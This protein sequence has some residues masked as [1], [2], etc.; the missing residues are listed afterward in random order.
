MFQLAIESELIG[1]YAFGFGGLHRLQGASEICT[2]HAYTRHAKRMLFFRVRPLITFS[3]D[4]SCHYTHCCCHPSQLM[5]SEVACSDAIR[6]AR[7][8]RVSSKGLSSLA[9]VHLKRSEAGAHTVFKRFGQSLHV[10]IS[11]TDLPSKKNFPYVSFTSWLKYL[12]E[13]D[14][15]QHLVGE[16]D[17]FAMKKILATF[18]S[19]FEAIHPDHV[20]CGRTDDNFSKDMCIP[21]CYHGDEGRGLK[22]KQLMVLSIH[23]VLGKGSHGSN[24]MNNDIDDPLG[25][26]RLNMVGNTFLTHFLQCVVPISLYTDS[27]ESFFH[28]I[29]LQ[30]RE[31]ADLFHTGLQIGQHRYWICCVA[32]KGDAPYLTKSG[33]F[34]RSFTRRPTRA[35]SKN[36]AT[37]VCHLC[38]AGREN[39]Q[40]SH[41]PYEEIGTT[42]PLWLRTV[43]VERP[44]S[45]E[46]PMLQIPHQIG[47]TTE[48]LWQ[49]DLF[50][51][52]HLGLG[53]RFATS[54]IAMCLELIPA[55]IDGAFDIIT[56]DFLQFCRTAKEYPYHKKLSKTM[57]GVEKSFGDCPEAGWSKGDFTRLL[58]KWFGSYCAREVVG[59]TDDPI[60]LK[61]VAWDIAVAALFFISL[62]FLCVL[63]LPYD[64]FQR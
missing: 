4:S 3:S 53:K 51:N 26:L 8:T 6:Q 11:R 37:G 34:D 25:P 22:K 56:A 52:F 19:R 62:Y 57:F 58:L 29:D 48:R 17:V 49:F 14:Q 40:G 12:V 63:T 21:V 60:C 64:F 47:G 13:N 59:K 7:V 50:Q 61:C 15:L 54:A 30:A 18:W 41:I 55:S 10:K 38:L 45:T 28:L 33:M 24:K 1:I 20:I 36:P 46:S 32:V 39:H 23:G 35:S 27:P 42:S 16:K 2:V 43:G 31:L 5:R 9:K 44:Y